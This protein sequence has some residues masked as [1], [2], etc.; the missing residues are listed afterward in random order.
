[1]TLYPLIIAYMCGDVEAHPSIMFIP[2][3]ISKGVMLLWRNLKSM[4]MNWTWRISVDYSKIFFTTYSCIAELLY[5]N[6][7]HT[8]SIL[9]KGVVEMSS[10][11]QEFFQC[12]GS[13]MCKIFE[14]T[15][16][17]NTWLYL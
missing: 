17:L 15:V 5:M 6:I 12:D 4:W 2:G 1:M 9:K 13:G 3:D 11:I 10:Y 16:V 8:E 14:L 7:G